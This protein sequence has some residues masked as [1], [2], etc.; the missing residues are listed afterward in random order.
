MLKRWVLS[1]YLNQERRSQVQTETSTFTTDQYIV[2]AEQQLKSKG[3]IRGTNNYM[4]IQTLKND[5]KIY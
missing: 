5:E 1:V 2:L 3:K 4:H